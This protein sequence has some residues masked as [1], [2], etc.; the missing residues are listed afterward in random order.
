MIR[1]IL[2]LLGVDYLRRRSVAMYGLGFAFVVAGIVLLV[3]SLGSYGYFPLK[4][5]AGLLV[6][7]GVCALVMAAI[8]TGAIRIGRVIEGIVFVL[9]ASLVMAGHHGGDFWLAMILG[10]VFALDGLLQSLSAV[11]VRYPRW[12]FALVGGLCEIAIAISFF[13]PYPFGYEVTVPYALSLALLFVGWGMIWIAVR[14]RLL[15]REA[16][17]GQLLRGALYQRPDVDG[18]GP[19]AAGKGPVVADPAPDAESAINVHIWT[20]AGT[21]R[22]IRLQRRPLIDRYVAAVDAHGVVWTGHA[23][24]EASPVYISLDP[25]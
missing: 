14:M 20:P 8:S 25:A 4:I 12:R 13:S 6:V 5:F 24:L 15:G 19:S 16:T 21:A 23:A 18:Q 22:Q 3:D 7:A 9:A 17:V 1:L 10:T 11:I 2:I